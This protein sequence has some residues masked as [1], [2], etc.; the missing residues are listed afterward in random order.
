MSLSITG[1]LK[2]RMT[3]L[4]QRTTSSAARSWRVEWV[5]E[6]RSWIPKFIGT[7][8]TGI[9]VR[10]FTFLLVVRRC[11]LDTICGKN[12]EHYFWSRVRNFMWHNARYE[13]SILRYA[14]TTQVNIEV[15]RPFSKNFVFYII[16]M[17]SLVI[18]IFKAIS[19]DGKHILRDK[20]D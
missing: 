3:E 12:Y 7:V 10:V 9:M 20:Y 13:R 1:L 18:Q 4:A 15:L 17:R 19:N 8:T 16:Q 6:E 11:Y 2:E 5:G 14:V